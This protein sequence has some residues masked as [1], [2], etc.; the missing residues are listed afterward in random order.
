MK[1]TPTLSLLLAAAAALGGL[2]QA[3][4]ASATWNGTTDNVWATDTNWSAT[5]APG[6]GDTATF[7]NAGNANTTLDLGAGVTIGSILFD[8]ASVATYTIGANGAGNQTLTLDDNGTI[9][10]T[11]TINATQTFNANL[12]LA[13]NATVTNSDTGSKLTFAGGISG[14]GTGTNTL[15]IN[16][17]TGGV[18]ISG[19]ITNGSA[20]SIALVKSGNGN[21]TLNGTNT[22]SG[23]TTLGAGGINVNSA[24]AIGT[25]TLTITGGTLNNTSGATVTLSN[26]NN[27]TWNGDF[28]F[29]GTGSNSTTGGLNF[30]T[31][32]ATLG[33]NITANVN[34]ATAG[35]RLTVANISAG[36][37]TFT[38]AGSGV[39]TVGPST[40]ATTINLNA[41]TVNGTTSGNWNSTGV[42]TNA[43]Y[44]GN[45][46]TS[47]NVTVGAVTFGGGVLAFGDKTTNTIGNVTIASGKA[48]GLYTGSGIAGNI[49]TGNLSVDGTL[50]LVTNFGNTV[51]AKGLSGSGNI[52]ATPVAGSSG[53]GNRNLFVGNSNVTST[54][55]GNLSDGGASRALSLTKVGNGNL[56]LSGTNTY[57]GSTTVNG[58]GRLII[59]GSGSINPTTGATLSLGGSSSAGTL[60]YDSSAASKFGS[61]NLG[62][63]T[64]SPGTLNQTA[65]T[66]NATSLT[67]NSGYSGNGPGTVGLS[68][69]TLAVS[70]ATV[71]SSQVSGD[72]IYSTITVSGSGNLTVGGNL[73]MTGAP[74]AGRNAAGRVMQN[75]G[76]VNVT[77]ILNMARTTT[78]NSAARRGE[79]NLNGG[80]LSVSQITQD[81]GTDTFGTFNFAGGTLKPTGSNATFMQGLTTANVKDGGAVIDTNGFDITIAQPLVKFAGSTTDTLT[82]NGAGNLTLTGNNTFTGTTAV[83]VGTLIVSGGGR[84]NTSTLVSVA[85]GATLTNDT[86]TALTSALALT[87]GSNLTGAGNFTT[88][89]VA[90]SADLGDGFTSINLGTTL[91]K[92]GGSSLDFS[93]SN[94]TDGT[95]A[96]FTNTA[97]TGFFSSVSVGGISLGVPVG[98]V[99]SANIGGTTYTYDDS[100]FGSL[101]VAVPEPGTW[102]LVG[103][104][105]TFLLY[106]KP[107]RFEP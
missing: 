71:V 81:V 22:Y 76:T 14:A 33:G 55:S 9:T 104:G 57:V 75:A 15:T 82:K 5:P 74:A 90:V 19:A 47:G 106:R 34:Q 16:S 87:E 32:T 88:S 72:N 28:T 105:L 49:T 65:G 29:T 62:G 80:T 102:I 10:A 59:S 95:Y 60:Q 67:L 99:F 61:I 73:F 83:N 23:G 68:G 36:S 86:A 44:L 58:G 79:Y 97:P 50:F 41:V 26:N 54:F 3:I 17:T 107:R 98:T 30:G 20:T 53:G 35:V 11:S 25:G 1:T 21:L 101:I 91:T 39:L 93:L 48:G 37:N 69:G 51:N 8:T 89:S 42:V 27:T 100:G 4:A 77:G 31:G 24:S 12:G 46:A 66:I 85:S 84:L 56:T 63:G 103:I 78:A 45:A 13:G 96:I 2:Q 52:Q 6:T 7:D 70:G 64:I 40:G 38:K 92:N 43:L 94:V 18:D